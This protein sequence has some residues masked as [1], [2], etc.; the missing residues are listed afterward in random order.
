MWTIDIPD[1][2]PH[3]LN[4]L[5]TAHRMK[6]ARMKK[7]DADFFAAYGF[8]AGVPKAKVK[9]WVRCTFFGWHSGR[10]PDPDAFFKSTLDGLVQARLLVDDSGKWCEWERPRIIPSK[11]RRTVVE[12][13][14]SPWVS[15]KDTQSEHQP[16]T[17]QDSQSQPISETKAESASTP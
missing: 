10:R 17:N 4:E 11:E 12:L 16:R 7:E 6:A 15:F 2:H 3:L 1:W 13:S 9:R 8:N 5:L 14:E